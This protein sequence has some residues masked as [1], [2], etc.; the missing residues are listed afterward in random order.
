MSLKMVVIVVLDN[1]QKIYILSPVTIA[2][3]IQFD[4][5]SR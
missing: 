2:G 1:L 4:S 3:M 5:C